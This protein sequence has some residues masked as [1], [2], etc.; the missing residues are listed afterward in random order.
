MYHLYFCSAI[1]TTYEFF[2]QVKKLLS[3]IIKK[4]ITK[5]GHKYIPLLKTLKI[6]NTC[7]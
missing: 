4:K 2:Y 7:D 3:T 5:L 6:S 1:N